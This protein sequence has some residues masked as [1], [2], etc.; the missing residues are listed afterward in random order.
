M[1]AVCFIS[2]K[3]EVRQRVENRKKLHLLAGKILLSSQNIHL[4]IN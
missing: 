1:V 4:E 3:S 2:I